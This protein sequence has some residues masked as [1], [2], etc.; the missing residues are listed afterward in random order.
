MIG[1]LEIA[2]NALATIAILLAGRNSI[3]TWWTGMLGCA[4]FT[5]LFFQSRLY[6]DVVLQ[7]FFVASSAVG[8]R[9]WLRGHRGQA[10]AVAPADFRSL[11]WTLPAGLGA[12]LAYGAM[13]H[14]WTDAYAPFLDSAVLVFSVIAQ[15]LLMGRRIENWLFWLAV[16]TIAV[17]L[18]ASRGLY[19]TAALY[20]V[21]W[22]NAVVAWRWWR[23]L[24][25]QP[26]EHA[27]PQRAGA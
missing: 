12:S 25:R 26:Q 2:A 9:Q 15:L 18:Y 5:L 21:Y 16:N 3:H 17:P 8:W 1:P 14:Y 11:A 10:L 20:A 23:R 27:Q 19:L 6:A 24:A 4:L 13:L 7:V 22:V